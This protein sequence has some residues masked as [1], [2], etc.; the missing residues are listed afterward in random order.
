[1]QRRNGR[2]DFVKEPIRAGDRVLVGEHMIAIDE[3]FA[4]T[5][6]P[7]D[8]VI[9]LA[10]TGDILRVPKSES[11]LV[12]KSVAAA[13]QAF[14]EMRECSDDA[15]SKF[16]EI[17]AQL[18]D[19]PEVVSEITAANALDV[20]DAKTR[21]RSTTRL[22]FTEP[23]RREM[24]DA[25]R[26]WQNFEP[27]RDVVTER[28]VHKGWVVDTV[29]SPLGVVG[30]VF[31]GRPNVFA[32]ATGVLRTGN[33]CVF[34][35]GSDAL[36][37]A[38]V[39][40]THAIEPAL[41]L[42]G[43]PSGAIVLID[44]KSHAAGWALFSDK[45]LAL[46]VARGSGPAVSQLGAIARQAGI[47]VSLHGTGGAWLIAGEH[48]DASVFESAVEHSLDR[49]LCNTLN[50]VCIVRSRA[51]DLLPS[52]Q[53]AV[54]K[55]AAAR[56]T[57]PVVHLVPDA[58]LKTFSFDLGVDVRDLALDS[59]ATEWEWDN[60]PECSVVMVGDLESAVTLCNEYSP[61]FVVSIVSDDE[62]ERDF[63]WRRVNA[64]F[65]GD[66]M[67]RWVDGQFALLRPELGLSNW[68]SG[69]M[70]GRGAILS[71]DSVHTVRYRVTQDDKNLRR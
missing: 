21:A 12:S 30:F 37:T 57:N 38:T 10:S 43:L 55:A 63:V 8:R 61:Q 32:D 46:A 35:I 68:Q 13:A 2:I 16:Y 28:V 18:L 3:A 70:L 11:D 54:I 65:V 52:F 5:I 62:R 33:T 40:M 14:I 4:A 19:S 31:E 44:A 48:C 24:V 69:R 7:G 58:N 50:V 51:G 47:A 6:E 29:T 49:K 20:A 25:L 67:T 64:P 23:M 1:M 45:R 26:I 42:S 66:G 60:A 59:L 27:N 36:R 17:F 9:G 41:R 15:I 34:R 53:R 71:G 22:E 39:I 56:G